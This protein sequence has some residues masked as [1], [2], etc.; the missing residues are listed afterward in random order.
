VIGARTVPRL[1]L[2]AMVA[3]ISLGDTRPAGAYLK[4]G[5]L[6]N[7]QQISVRW[8]RAPVSYRVTERDITGVT[9]SDLRDAA[10]RAFAKWQDV[11]TASIGYQFAG[12][13]RA[14]P[15]QD[16]GITTL[17]FDQRPD[18]DRVLA[19]TSLLVD[20]VTGEIVEA[21]ILFNSSFPWSVSATGEPGRYDLETIA[22]H[23]IGHLS[24]LGHSALG[25]TELTSVG[26]RVISAESVMFPIA[27]NAGIVTNRTLRADDIAGISDLYPAGRFR[28][29]TGSISGRVTLNGQGILGAHVVAFNPSSGA[30]IG[31]FTLDEQGRF[32]IAGLRPGP[33]I[34]RIEPL[35]DADVESFFDPTSV[36]LDFKVSIDKR[37]V[38]A[39]K[40]GDSG[41]VV[42]QVMPK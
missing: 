9:A 20:E 21:D 38:T 3:A 24:G 22:L 28:S 14:L 1:G 37:L 33:Y 36:V 32:S 23:E 29:D 27:F 34:I 7:G 8:A 26:R 12:F 25:E 11:A 39:P 16:D 10:G 31:G 30:L 35:D 15:G 19:S 41:A 18:L 5:V 2:L 13:T 4:F 6:A 42:L 17:G 40:G